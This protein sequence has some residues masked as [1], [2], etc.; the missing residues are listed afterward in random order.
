VQELIGWWEGIRGDNS[1]VY[2]HGASL[3]C[4]VGQIIHV[5][6]VAWRTLGLWFGRGHFVY[7]YVMIPCCS[8]MLEHL[9]HV[10]MQSTLYD[11]DL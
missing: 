7:E 6:W 3:R 4:C 5:F 8:D 11:Q 9:S 2:Y 10:C 1:I